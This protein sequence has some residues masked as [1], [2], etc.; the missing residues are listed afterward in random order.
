MGAG[1]L[2]ADTSVKVHIAVVKHHV[3][4]GTAPP[5]REAP[6]ECLAAP[7][8]VLIQHD[9]GR[10][11]ERIDQY[12]HGRGV[13]ARIP[14]RLGPSDDLV[15]AVDLLDRQSERLHPDVRQDRAPQR[16]RRRVLDLT[17]VADD[18]FANASD[19]VLGRQLG[20]ERVQQRPGVCAQAW[21]REDHC[22]RHGRPG[23]LVLD[24]PGGIGRR[25]HRVGVQGQRDGEPGH[26]PHSL[27]VTDLDEIC[28]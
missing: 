9:V 23:E 1:E 15:V 22:Q 25:N 14:Q 3:L 18:C 17:S 24:P 2:H 27:S 5:G 8:I 19:Q 20:V 7:R 26:V 11:C 12:E 28:D 13:R 6:D 10:Q 4:T 16:Q 21:G